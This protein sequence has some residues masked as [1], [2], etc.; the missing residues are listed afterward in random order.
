MPQQLLRDTRMDTGSDE[1]ARRTMPEI[2]KS[3]PREPGDFQKRLEVLGQPRTIDRVT[4]RSHENESHVA[5]DI[6]P[7][8]TQALAMRAQTLDNERRLKGTGAWR[9]GAHPIPKSL[10]RPSCRDQGPLAR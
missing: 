8:D 1:Q 2:M 3:H 5:P 6:G 7:L 4:S 9:D 10:L